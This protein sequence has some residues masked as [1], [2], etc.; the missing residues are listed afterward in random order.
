[1]LS[2]PRILLAMQISYD[3][4]HELLCTLSVMNFIFW[5]WSSWSCTNPSWLMVSFWKCKGT[6]WPDWAKP[7]SK[8][9]YLYACSENPTRKLRQ[10][11]ATKSSLPPFWQ[12]GYKLLVNIVLVTNCNNISERFKSP[13]AMTHILI[14]IV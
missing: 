9:I 4:E 6:N 12:K 3:H 11:R 14:H 8:Y 7:S 5:R 10:I 1:M 2:N 13:Q